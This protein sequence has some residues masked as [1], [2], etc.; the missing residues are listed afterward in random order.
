MKQTLFTISVVS[1]AAD[2]YAVRNKIKI[3]TD[4]SQLD[5]NYSKLMQSLNN[6]IN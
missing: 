1:A 6:R 2:P 3:I 4:A 5:P